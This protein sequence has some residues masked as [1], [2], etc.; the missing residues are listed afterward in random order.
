MGSVLI[1]F[2]QETMLTPLI[3]HQCNQADSA[4]VSINGFNPL[5]NS[6]YSHAS[7]LCYF[8]LV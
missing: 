2:L 6:L 5:S 8:S 4:I 7:F 3:F 1:I